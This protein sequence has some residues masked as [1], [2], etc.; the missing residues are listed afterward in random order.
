MG[1]GRR[2]VGDR[3]TDRSYAFDATGSAHGP[4]PRPILAGIAT[5][6]DAQEGIGA[7]LETVIAVVGSFLRRLG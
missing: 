6:S 7:F 1:F 2:H 4:G 5:T 3:G